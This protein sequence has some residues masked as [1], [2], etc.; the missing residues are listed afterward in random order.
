MSAVFPKTIDEAFARITPEACKSI[1][2]QGAHFAVA[3]ETQAGRWFVLHAVDLDHAL[4]I[5]RDRVDNFLCRGASIW[6]IYPDGLASRN[7]AAIYEDAWRG[8]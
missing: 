5:A 2:A 3:C 1:L 8:A 7:C 4:N 6:R